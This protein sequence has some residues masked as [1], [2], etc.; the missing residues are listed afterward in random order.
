MLLS[1]LMVRMNQGRTVARNLS[2]QFV[3][4]AEL[5]SAYTSCMDYVLQGLTVATNWSSVLISRALTSCY[6]LPTSLEINICRWLDVG[7]ATCADSCICTSRIKYW[8]ANILGG[9]N[10]YRGF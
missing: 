5:S 8:N 7:R 4:I 1:D 10:P 2:I 9:H 3:S 6:K